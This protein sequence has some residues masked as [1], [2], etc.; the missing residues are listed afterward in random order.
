MGARAA[1][2]WLVAPPRC[3]PHR[4]YRAP[5]PPVAPGLVAA[6]QPR[7]A[8][9]L[10]ARDDGPALNVLAVAFP[11]APRRGGPPVLCGRLAQPQAAGRLPVRGLA[12]RAAGLWSAGGFDRVG[13]RRSLPG[14][15]RTPPQALA[16][17]AGCGN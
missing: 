16:E 9:R 1:W 7:Q 3:R 5:G 10:G 8:L 14:G 6:G 11:I 2:F 15:A 4:G 13:A 12:K 17:T